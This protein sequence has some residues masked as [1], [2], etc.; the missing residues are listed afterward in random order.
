MHHPNARGDALTEACID[1]CLACYR[2]CLSA[3]M[4]HCLETGGAHVAPPHFRLMMACAEICRASAHVMVT[5]A[6]GH[7]GVCAACAVICRTCAADCDRLDGMADCAA[8]CRT[9]ADA[10]EGMAH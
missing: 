4:G 1:A 7:A 3:A 2:T 8:A 6:E 10:C 5:G 9:C